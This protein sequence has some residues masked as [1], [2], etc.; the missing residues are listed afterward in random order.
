MNDIGDTLK[1][2]ELLHPEFNLK[3]GRKGN[4]VVAELSIGGHRPA[5]VI[6]DDLGTVIGQTHALAV[7]NIAEDLLA[8]SRL[9]EAMFDGAVEDME[10]DRC[11]GCG[12]CNPDYD[13]DYYDEDDDN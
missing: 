3:L 7:R 5:T 13:D 1:R 2:I 6:G 11:C 8:Q 10:G 9:S 4:Q 12:G